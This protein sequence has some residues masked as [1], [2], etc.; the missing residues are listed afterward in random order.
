MNGKKRNSSIGMLS[1]VLCYWFHYMMGYKFNIPWNETCIFLLFLFI[2]ALY[3]LPSLE[4]PS[5]R[6]QDLHY[7][8]CCHS[9]TCLFIHYVCVYVFL[10]QEL[11]ELR[12]R[13]QTLTVA[14]AELASVSPTTHE[15]REDTQAIAHLEEGE[16]RDTGGS[17][18]EE[19]CL[20]TNAEKEMTENRCQKGRDKAAR[21]LQTN[22]REHRNKV[23]KAPQSH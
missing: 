11:E 3:L 2:C 16:E 18:A 17:N 19:E 4:S 8:C 9:V 23:C 22:W 5:C 12:E 20:G 10:R 6:W 7:G 21:I 1:L 14:Q 15:N 13:I